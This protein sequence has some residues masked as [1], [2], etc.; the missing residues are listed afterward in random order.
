[1]LRRLFVIMIILILIIAAGWLALR[2][3]DIPYQSLE[4]FYTSQESEFLTL[5]DGVKLHYRDEGLASGETLVLV[6]GFAAS[7]H[8]WEPWVNRLGTDYRIISLDLPGHGL[9]RNPEGD[10][11]NP[12]YF[13]EAIAEMTTQL[14]VDEFVLVGSSM[15]G[16]TAWQFALEYPD[17]LEGLVLVAASGWPN[18][19]QAGRPL[20]FS[21]LDNSLARFLMKDLDMSSLVASGLQDSFVD[22]DLV[23]DEMI[24]RY[25]SLSRAPGHREGILAMTAQRG[26]RV[27][28]TDELVGRIDVPTLILQ[29]REDNLVNASGAERFA[30]AIAG[31]EVTVYENVGHLPQEEIADRS[32][33][34]LRAF[35]DRRI[36]PVV[37][38]APQSDPASDEALVPAP[39]E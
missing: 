9:S 12:G 1:M 29:G 19:D 26:D 14:G 33:A 34:D 27:V 30:A 18:E 24:E 20:V 15:G 7:L 39:A 31:S 17:R 16:A 13:G 35:L 3:A 38:T 6:H 36:W 4:T 2:R 21:L 23:T 22:P 37:E 32:A 28:A 25:V 8:T 10:K 11:M 5:S